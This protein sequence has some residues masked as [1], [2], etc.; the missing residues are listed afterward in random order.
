MNLLRRAAMRVSALAFAV[1]LP[2]SAH[3]EGGSAL[4][5]LRSLAATCA[6]CHGTDGRPAP[7]S[8]VAALAGLPEPQLLAQMAGFRAGTRP[9]TVMTQLANGYTDLQIRQLAAYFAGQTR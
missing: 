4:L 3:A 2:F 8:I 7:G 6:Q 5:Q 1:A 9:A